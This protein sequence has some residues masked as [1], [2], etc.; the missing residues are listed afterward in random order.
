VAIIRPVSDLQRKTGELS[1]LAIE[2]KEPIY[3]TKN[4]VEYLVL[5]DAKEYEALSKKTR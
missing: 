4:G 3:L 2:S 5:L 1:K